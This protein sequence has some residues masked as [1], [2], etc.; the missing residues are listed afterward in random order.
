MNKETVPY[1]SLCTEYYELERPNAPEEALQC[2]LQF[3]KEAHGPILEPMCGSGRF[4]IPLLQQGYAITGFDYSSHMLD[5]CRKK[6]N[7]L[8]L[9]PD[10]QEATFETFSHSDSYHLIFIPSGSF[11]HLITPEQVTRALKFVVDR[12]KKGGKFVFEVETLKA[13][14]SPQGVW[15]G[16]WVSKPDG[17]K[18]VR[19]F[20]THFDPSSSIETGLFR[21]ELWERNA[22]TRAEVESFYLRLYRPSEIERLL[23]EHGLKIVNKRQTETYETVEASESSPV[24]LYECVKN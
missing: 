20:L 9:N 13:V 16:S 19:N 8:G 2:Y 5:M 18:I 23:D 10:L 24:I 21:Y 6:C 12:L 3:A 22:I 15:R 7:A 4:L 14:R 17:S 11:C 1:G